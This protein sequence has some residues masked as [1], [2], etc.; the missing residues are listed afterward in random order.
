M[1]ELVRKAAQ[2]LL[3][4]HENNNGSREFK[5]REYQMAM[6]MICS[7]VNEV[8]IERGCPA[9]YFLTSR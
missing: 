7:R 2:L 9:T 4:L 3:K 8:A 5:Y 1:R 6:C